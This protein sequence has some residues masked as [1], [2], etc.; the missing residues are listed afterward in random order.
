[1]TAAAKD[2][3]QRPTPALNV[4]DP[5]LYAHGDPLPVWRELRATAPVHWNDTGVP[6]E[7]F[8]A[9][10]TYEPAVQVY[11]GTNTFTSERGMRLGSGRHG[12]D[13]AAGRMMI[14]TDPPRHTKLRNLMNSAFTPRRTAQMEQ[15]MRDVLTPLIDEAV[16]TGVVDFVTDIAAVLPAAIVCHI[17][18]VAR[19]EHQAFT[20]M[21]SRAFG[22][23]LGAEGG[24]VSVAASTVANAK[25]FAYYARLLEQRRAAPGDDV[26]ST[27]ATSEVDG[28]PLTDAEIV[29]N[30]NGILLGA[31]ETTR[32]ASAGGLLALIE[33]P[34]QW[35]RLRDGD[36]SPDSAVEEVLR[37][38]SP[39]MHM[40]RVAR[41]DT[42][43]GGQTIKAG[44]TV[45]IWNPSAN[46][47]EA[48]FD[49]PDRL[50]LGRTPNRHLAFGMGSHF[51][52]GA[53]LARIELRV[54]LQL[55]VDRLSGAELAG[56]V[57]TMHSNF[58]WGVEHMPVTLL[59]K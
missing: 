46:R 53:A 36:V 5:A 47:D 26:V 51:C 44:E 21:T 10:M 39:A 28:V 8:W 17:M 22:A 35:Q 27:L 23:N 9:V 50:D 30:C 7:A 52:I 18:D 43:I 6:G 13:A 3:A 40:K 1:M 41:T 48:V 16:E 15:T 59:P 55:L 29:M 19:E 38:T 37:Y 56:P 4:A 31:N 34:A 32:L 2:R 49:R 11:K 42:E 20:D 54:M 24:P 25:I 14:V 33:N 58:M 12:V 57:R 45:A